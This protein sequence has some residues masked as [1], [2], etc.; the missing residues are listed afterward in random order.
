MIEFK[1]T[2]SK[3]IDENLYQEKIEEA[4]GYVAR[5]QQDDFGGW[6]DLPLNYDKDEFARLKVAA[7]KIN[8]DSDILVCIGIGGSYLGHRAVIEA[9]GGERG[10][11]KIV[12]AGNSLSPRMLEKAVA[13]IEG[14][15]FSVN[16]I[17]KS[18]TT[19]EPAVAFRIFKQLLIDKYGET[20][21]AKRI[22]AT[23]DANKGALH[24]EAVAKGYET[25]VVPDNI[26]GRYSVL[27]AVGLLAIAVAGIDI[28]RLMDGA[29][30]E[31]TALISDGG[32]AAEYAAM[33]NVLLEKGYDIEILA[34]FEP[35]FS[36]FNEWWK[37]LF[38]ES[39][40]KDGKG[41]YPAS[42]VDSTDLH[43]MGQY[44]QEGR[45]AL[46][47]TF[48]EVGGSYRGVIVPE[49]GEN[50]DGLQYLEGKEMDYINKTANEATRE[51]HIAGGVPVLEIVMPDIDE[52]SLGGLIYFFEM[53]CAL[54]GFTLGVNP[55]NQPGVEAYKT[56]MFELLGKPGYDK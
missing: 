41:I 44:I 32:K 39:E 10:R 1:Y 21:A 46:F 13:E 12:Y 2:P 48:V 23:T 51:A 9:L 3:L 47:E 34:N 42:V 29:V 31:R 24:D 37:Q 30:E 5:A 27:T 55:F 45:R 18:G 15:D 35:Q 28:D 22:Y 8:E 25:F 11:T 52:R 40:G 54:S 14:K 50:L 33:R 53:S 6:V 4:R 20:E 36:Q 19:T 43:S 26:G 16:V 17:S 49:F 7:K 38:G 56:R